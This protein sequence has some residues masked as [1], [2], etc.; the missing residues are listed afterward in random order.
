MNLW[1]LACPARFA[2]LIPSL[3][4]SSDFPKNLPRKMRA[5]CA[6]LC[7]QPASHRPSQHLSLDM[8]FG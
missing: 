6:I 3:I 7:S 1:P 5:T 4:F 8:E 2:P